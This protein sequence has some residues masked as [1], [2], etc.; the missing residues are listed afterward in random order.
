[1]DRDDGYESEEL[2]RWL[3]EAGRRKIAPREDVHACLQALSAPVEAGRAPATHAK[4][5]ALLALLVF[6]F[7]QYYYFDVNL[8]ILSQPSLVVFVPTH[9]AASPL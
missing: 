6:S 5:L 1:M 8:K 4:H 3:Q 7:L 9:G 2:V